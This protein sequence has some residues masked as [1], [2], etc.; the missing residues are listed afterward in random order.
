MLGC[1]LGLAFL[2]VSRILLESELV[3]GAV[4][5]PR[6][7][8]C[9]LGDFAQGVLSRWGLLVAVEGVVSY[10][11]TCTAGLLWA[12]LVEMIRGVA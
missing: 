12:V 4:P 9:L 1:R 3:S 5:C 2:E 8:W 10:A 7:G 11:A 6:G